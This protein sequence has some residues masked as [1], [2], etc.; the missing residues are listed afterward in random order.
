MTVWI[1][2]LCHIWI[3][4]QHMQTMGTAVYTVRQLFKI[5]HCVR[6]FNTQPSAACRIKVIDYDLL[7]RRGVRAGFQCKSRSITQ[8]TIKRLRAKQYGVNFGNL[9]TIS[10][11]TR[12]LRRAN[13][14]TVNARSLGSSGDHIR[15]MILHDDLDIITITETWL[16]DSSAYEAAK[17]CPEG[18]TLIRSDRKEPRNGGGVA[19]LCR[20]ELQPKKT[21]SS[22]FDSFEHDMISVCASAVKATVAV[23]YRP[24]SHSVGQ[25]LIDFT[26]FLE[27]TLI[28]DNNI[29]ISGDFNIHMDNESD[30][31]CHRIKVHSANI[32][33]CSEGG[34]TNTQQRSYI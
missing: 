20:D 1:A 23:V 8:P 15:H 27:D 16:R 18:F 10:T 2:L 25:F 31:I 34:R 17:I 22:Q 29:V 13:F 12:S 11:R 32:R 9:I 3:S 19:I 28:S 24:P 30:R 5:G 21:K 33:P 7:R 6:L 4:T 26:T 14:A